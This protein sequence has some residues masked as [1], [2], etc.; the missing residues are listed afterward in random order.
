M[1]RSEAEPAAQEEQDPD[2]KIEAVAVAARV[3]VRTCLA[4]EGCVGV[5][6]VVVGRL[7]PGEQNMVKKGRAAK[8]SHQAF[9]TDTHMSNLSKQSR[10]FWT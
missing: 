8:L 5:A 2:S 6:L 7:R 1:A 9:A 3:V 10:S 4:G